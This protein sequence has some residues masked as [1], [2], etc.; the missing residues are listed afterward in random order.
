MQMLAIINYK[1]QIEVSAG[2]W[3]DA[4]PPS[5]REVAEQS[6]VGGSVLSQ[7]RH[8]PSLIA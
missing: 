2:R 7:E 5:L 4:L 8:S 1:L 6:K 3:N